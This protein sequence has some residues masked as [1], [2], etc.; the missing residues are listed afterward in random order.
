MEEDHTF[1]WLVGL[2]E[3]E[4]SFGYKAQTRTPVIELEMTDEH[5]IARVA[6]FFG[7][8][9]FRRDRRGSVR[10]GQ[11]LQ[12]SY[13][14]YIAGARSMRLMKGLQPFLSPRRSRQIDAVEAQYLAGRWNTIDYINLPLPTFESVPFSLTRE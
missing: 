11:S 10:A 14:C 6:S 8:S 5:I 12:V 1:F 9:Y 3:G 4:A 2:F 7:I 13:R